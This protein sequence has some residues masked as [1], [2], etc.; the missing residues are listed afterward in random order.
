VV[1]QYSSLDVSLGQPEK[2]QQ[3]AIVRCAKSH[4]LRWLARGDA[5]AEQ[6]EA[7]EAKESGVLG[8]PDDCQSLNGGYRFAT[9]EDG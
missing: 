1:H 6:R 5:S 8:V 4:E 7:E 9:Q 2:S 3:S